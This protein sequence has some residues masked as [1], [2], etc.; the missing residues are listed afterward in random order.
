MRRGKTQKLKDFLFFPLRALLLFN[1]D[2]W[3]LSS[4]RSERFDYVARDALGHCLDVGCGP[5]NLFVRRYLDG[6]GAGIDI[7]PYDGLTEQNI[8]KDVARF[9]FQ[10]NSFDS[11]T[12]IACINHIPKSMRDAELAEAYRC[13]KPS[14][15]IIIT[16]GSPL[17]EIIVHKVVS[18]YDRLFGTQHDIDSQR[19]MH[20]E[21]AYYLTD[22]EIID[23]LSRAGFVNIT[24][25]YFLTQWGLNHLFTAWKTSNNLIRAHRANNKK[26]GR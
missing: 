5:H 16:M 20:E 25:K 2:R 17:A 4:L 24:K 1:D 26:A 10:S 14:G 3:G 15:N 19:R 7:F 9:R 8:L 23:R 21:E 18:L 6:C 22:S 11:V 13:L 12:F